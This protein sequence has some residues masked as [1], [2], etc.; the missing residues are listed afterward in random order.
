MQCSLVWLAKGERWVVKLVPISLCL[1]GSIQLALISNSC[2][3]AFKSCFQP[4]WTKVKMDALLVHP[5]E[6]YWPR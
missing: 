3:H 6:Q 5:G 1:G 2:M 4:G